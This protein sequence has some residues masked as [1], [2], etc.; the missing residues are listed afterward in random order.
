MSSLGLNAP[1]LQMLVTGSS[2][3]ADHTENER[4]INL[5]YEF[6]GLFRSRPVLKVR[7]YATFST[8]DIVND[9]R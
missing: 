4:S 5:Q 7:D 8:K 3:T 9:R 1:M 2:G 6:E